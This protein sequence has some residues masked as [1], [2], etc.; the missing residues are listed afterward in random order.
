MG[1]AVL[2]LDETEESSQRAER[3][4]SNAKK[5]HAATRIEMEEVRALVQEFDKRLVDPSEDL[6]GLKLAFTQL[7]DRM[8][9]FG[10][11]WQSLLKDVEQ[12][13]TKR[14]EELQFTKLYVKDV[15]FRLNTLVI[16][17]SDESQKEY[18]L[19]RRGG[20][21]GISEARVLELIDMASPDVGTWNYKAGV[22]GTATL[23]GGKRVTRITAIALG[24]GGTVQI[25]GG[26]SIP[27][28]YDS[29]D[30]TSSDLTIEPKGNLVD[31]T[32]IFTGTDA[33]VIEW[34]TG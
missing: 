3:L 21:G 30:K 2:A 19:P 16:T 29:T 32:I 6:A 11:V 9:L 12:R 17:F 5:F 13:F 33:Y 28:P 7:S 14:A 25:N 15:R 34:V 24:A 18:P 8:S 27:V 31:P 26:D 4:E 10:G 20:G 1:V 22:S 23:T